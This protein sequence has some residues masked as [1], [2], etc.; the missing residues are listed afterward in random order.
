MIFGVLV[1]LC[2]IVT[3]ILAVNYS[4]SGK[5]YF[6][7]TEDGCVF[8]K[9]GQGKFATKEKCQKSCEKNLD[10]KTSLLGTKPTPMPIVKPPVNKP[11]THTPSHSP[12]PKTV[13][14]NNENAFFNDDPKVSQDLKN[15]VK[16]PF[17]SNFLNTINVDNIAEEI[18]KK[19]QSIPYYATTKK[20]N[21]VVTDHDTFPY[22]RWYRG[23]VKSTEPIV[24]EREAGWRP[25]HDFS[26]VDNL[27]SV[28]SEDYKF[29]EGCEDTRKI[30]NFN[31]YMNTTRHHYCYDANGQIKSTFTCNYKEPNCYDNSPAHCGADGKRETHYCNAF[32][33]GSAQH[34]FTC[35]EGDP[36]CVDDSP[37]YCPPGR[38]FE[39]HVCNNYDD[40]DPRHVFFCNPDISP[41][42][43]DDSPQYCNNI[44][45]SE[46][47]CSDATAHSGRRFICP[48]G[49]RHCFPDN[50]SPL[51]D[52]AD[53]DNLNNLPEGQV[54]CSGTPAQCEASNSCLNP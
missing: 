45:M 32:P 20:A 42:C 19:K 30:D 11:S 31:D 47:V 46:F 29:D 8:V 4:Q 18:R 2:L 41:W 50:S 6:N 26:Y 9:N 28:L 39:R 7:C 15:I 16:Q 35:I 48:T 3:T 54:H 12:G 25:R 23:Q 44:Q 24:V 36:G 37:T 53:P 22:P 17:N 14:S 43:S 10:K 33:V 21:Q 52:P 34:T 49:S 27:E 51:F 13:P 38:N 40:A 5:K 1:T